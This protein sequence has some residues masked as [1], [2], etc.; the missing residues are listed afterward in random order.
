MNIFIDKD[1]PDDCKL[2]LTPNIACIVPG[3]AWD[4][5]I[6]ITLDSVI[7]SIIVKLKTFFDAL[8]V[9]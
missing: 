7:A 9:T 3:H 4:S 1:I 2:F 8:I 5:L 6:S